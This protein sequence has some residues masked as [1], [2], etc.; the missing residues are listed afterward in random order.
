MQS[1]WGRLLAEIFILKC[2]ETT[3]H[4]KNRNQKVAV[5]A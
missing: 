3:G 1:A 5:L 2:L 4:K